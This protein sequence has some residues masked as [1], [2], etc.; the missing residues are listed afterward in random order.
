MPVWLPIYKRKGSRTNPNNYRGI[1]LLNVAGKVLASVLES[2]IK[3][4]FNNWID[5]AQNG[6]RPRRS[7]AHAIHIL[8]RIQEGC[9]RRNVWAAAVFID[10]KKAFDS[11]PRGV[12]FESLQWIGVPPD[13]LAVIQAIYVDPKCK[14]VGIKSW[15]RVARGECQ[16]CVL[17]LTMFLVALEMCMR[18]AKLQ[19]KGIEF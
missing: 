11:P 1:F 14:V 2:R 13:V 19:D 12:L 6:F 7:T 3:Q 9:R 8:Q 4:L 18:A 5:D 17:G 10:F 15:F 16:G